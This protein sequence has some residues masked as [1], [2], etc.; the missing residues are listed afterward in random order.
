MIYI[1]Q[2]NTLTILRQT[3]VGLYLGDEAGFEVLLPN[4]YLPESFKIGDKIQI[5]LYKDGQ[6]RPV[7]TTL[8]PKIT[9][10][11]FAFLKVSYINAYGAFLDW[12]LE[13]DLFLPYAEQPEHIEIGK[14][15]L[16]YMY[17]DKNSSRLVA[18]AHWSKFLKKEPESL[19]AGQKV[20][21]LIAEKTPIGYRVIIDSQYKGLLYADEVF[22]FIR[23]GDRKEGWIKQ[24]RED[25]KIDITLY[26]QGFTHRI[27]SDTDKILNHLKDG[28]GFLPL[29][30]SS[31]PE[32]ISEVLGISKKSFK[33]AVGVLYKSDKIT[34]TPEGIHL[35]N[36]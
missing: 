2:Y 28:K 32:M 12:G 14:Y 36:P 5:F 17:L 24:I 20:S 31:S 29:T 22:E 1:G 25:K 15:Y 7:A 33:R 4:K 10:H 19:V 35:K 27:E 16:V 26:P 9:L 8:T 13:K 11:E 18:S 23:V 30:D 6:D 34:L 3:S 21:L